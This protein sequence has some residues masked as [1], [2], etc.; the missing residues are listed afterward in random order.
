[1]LYLYEVEEVRKLIIILF[2]AVESQ[3][4]IRGFPMLM[5]YAKRIHD[6]YFPEY[7][8]WDTRK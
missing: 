8:F 4:V 6:R 3:Q 7:E 1:M 5:D 2:R